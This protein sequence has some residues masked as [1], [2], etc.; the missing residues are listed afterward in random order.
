MTIY[1]KDLED[2]VYDCISEKLAGLKGVNRAAKRDTGEVNDLKLRIK[3]VEKAE[4]QLVDTMLAGG[5]NEN[6]LVLANQ[7]ATQ[8]KRDKQVL[9]DRLDDLKSRDNEADVVVNLAKSWRTADYNRKK[10]VAGIMIHKIV[11]GEDGGAK[12]WWNI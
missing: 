11:I 2:M 12:I 5:F 7:K 3:A 10:A 1:A 6:L 9:Y 8:L 4:Q